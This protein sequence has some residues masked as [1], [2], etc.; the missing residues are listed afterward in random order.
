LEIQREQ[1]IKQALYGYLL[2]KREESAISL[3][4]TVSNTRI[5]DPAITNEAPVS[6]R[7]ILIALAALIVGVSIPIGS[8]YAKGLLDDKVGN[9]RDVEKATDAPV[10]GELVHHDE[11]EALVVKKG[12]RTAISELFRLIRTNLQFAAPGK[13]A[14]VLMV[15]SSMSGEG[16]TFFSIN[17]GASLALSGKK[18][19]LLEFDIRKPKLM[20]DIGLSSQKGRG[21]TSFLV[22]EDI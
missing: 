2:Q 5:I 17:V 11:E 20:K 7:K 21:F 22:Y 13:E 15:T 19:V 16:K 10:L 9:M 12:S 8:I 14:K 18:V 4:S 1:G 3:A 6:P